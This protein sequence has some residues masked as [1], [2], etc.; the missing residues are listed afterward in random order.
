[1][2]APSDPPYGIVYIRLPAPS[3]NS[4]T[5]PC[6]EDAQDGGTRSKTRLIKQMIRQKGFSCSCCYHDKD[7]D[8]DDD[9]EST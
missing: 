4:S 6:T 7:V 9:D 8:A 1:M 3:I 5:R 2:T